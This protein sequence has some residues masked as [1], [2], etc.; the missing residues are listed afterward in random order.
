MFGLLRAE[1]NYVKQTKTDGYYVDL[2]IDT[3]SDVSEMLD[4]SVCCYSACMLLQTNLDN[5]L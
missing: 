2:Y 3:I 1:K 5:T 4:Y